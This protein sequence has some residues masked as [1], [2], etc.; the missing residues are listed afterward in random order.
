MEETQWESTNTETNTE[1]LKKPAKI[2]LPRTL[3]NFLVHVKK[4][5]SN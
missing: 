2:T 5:I 4:N 1:F 3:L